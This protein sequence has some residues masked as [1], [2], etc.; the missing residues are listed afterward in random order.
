MASARHMPVDDLLR[1]ALDCYLAQGWLTET[2]AY[3]RR[4]AA[5]M[6]ITEDDV[7]RLVKEYR[8]EQRDASNH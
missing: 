4:K 1:Q 5:E 6:G 2:Q 8:R 3:G 7:D